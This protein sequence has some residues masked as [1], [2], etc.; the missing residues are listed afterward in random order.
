MQHMVNM[1][2][3]YAMAPIRLFGRSRTFRLALVGV[4][5]L[6]GSFYAALWALD[7]FMPSQ[8]AKSPALARIHAM[9]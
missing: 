1:A 7:R 4:V 8:P 3:Y 2:I 9:P 6:A 5:V